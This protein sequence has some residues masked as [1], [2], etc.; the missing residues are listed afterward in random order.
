MRSPKKNAYS[1]SVQQDFDTILH[2]NVDIGSEIYRK[3][4]GCFATSE[5]IN[6]GK[7]KSD[8]GNQSRRLQ[9]NDPEKLYEGPR[10]LRVTDLIDPQFQT[11]KH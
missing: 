8:Q 5:K 4:M 9:R 11:V 1:A 6:K 7:K 2:P 3:F 10:H